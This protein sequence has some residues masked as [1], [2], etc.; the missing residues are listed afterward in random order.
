MIQ[1]RRQYDY[2][3]TFNGSEGTIYRVGANG[4]KE[5][6]G[7]ITE[8]SISIDWTTEEVNQAGQPFGPA[9]KPG[10]RTITGSITA[11]V[12]WDRSEWL[13]LAIGSPRNS[14]SRSRIE[15]FNILAWM[16]D[17]HTPEAGEQQVTLVNCWVSSL[18]S[19]LLA[20]DNRDTTFTAT[21]QIEDVIM[22][23]AFS[24]LPTMITNNEIVT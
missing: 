9:T 14:N 8:I 5:E 23:N 17:R 4:R 22:P 2:F 7:E 20:V 18:E 6:C 10:V 19:P 16:S 11:R 15:R 3:S 1:H 24:R 21:I 13:R 12:S